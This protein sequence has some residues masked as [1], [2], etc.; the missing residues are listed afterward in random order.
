MSRG[1]FRARDLREALKAVA[2]VGQAVS[3]IEID[4]ASGRIIIVTGNG[5]AEEPATD[6]DRWM[7]TH[8]R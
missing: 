5:A 3:K 1:P 7:A 2:A 6:L 4:P 8:A